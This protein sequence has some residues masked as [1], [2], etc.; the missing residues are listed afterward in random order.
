M[1]KGGREGGKEGDGGRL[2]QISS[3]TPSSLIAK[4]DRRV[5]QR[6]CGNKESDRRV[7]EATENSG[8]GGAW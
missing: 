4:S 3:L 2:A 1:R 5:E 8:G 6:S 7:V